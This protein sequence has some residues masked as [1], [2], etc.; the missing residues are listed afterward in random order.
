M[1]DYKGTGHDYWQQF[2]ASEDLSRGVPNTPSSFA[3]WVRTSIKTS[4][5]T[6]IVELGSGNGRDALWFARLGYLVSGY[7]FAESAVRSAQLRADSESLPAS[8]RSLD[9]HDSTQLEGAAKAVSA[10]QMPVVLYARFLIHSLQDTGRFNLI[11]FAATC[12]SNGG[13]LFLEFR[14]AQDQGRRHLFGDS[15][16]RNYLDPDLVISEVENRGG[17]IIYREVG[18]G[19]AVYKSEDPKVARLVFDWTG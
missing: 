1:P 14:T 12:L 17:R 4:T 9:L 13:E 19:L 15:H 18:Y 3:R 11:D 5:R 8:F 2:Y 16:Y 7:D 10:C 6:H